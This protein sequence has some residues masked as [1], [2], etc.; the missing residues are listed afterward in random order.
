ME[1]RSQEFQPAPASPLQTHF[2]FSATS[3]SPWAVFFFFFNGWGGGDLEAAG[4]KDREQVAMVTASSVRGA[5]A[6][7]TGKM[8]KKD[9]G[10]G[11]VTCHSSF[12]PGP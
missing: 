10:G 7:V 12:Q 4:K 6:R 8:E 1:A 9:E 3:S 11:G 2:C 5:V